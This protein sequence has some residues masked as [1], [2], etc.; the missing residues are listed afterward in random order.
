MDLILP[1]FSSLKDQ[2]LPLAYDLMGYVA[3]SSRKRISQLCG[4][5]RVHAKHMG[6][7]ILADET[8]S[9]GASTA[10]AVIGTTSQHR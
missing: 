10:V 8:Y 3:V 6:H 2:K 7:A 9:G 1:F 4:V 5:Y